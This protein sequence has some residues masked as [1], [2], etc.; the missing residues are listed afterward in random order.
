M[1]EPTSSMRSVR[2]DRPLV[3]PGL[4]AGHTPPV[5]SIR[6]LPVIPDKEPKRL[7]L[8]ALMALLDFAALASAFLLANLLYFGNA[9]ID[10][11]IA[12]AAT[13]I[14]IYFGFSFMNTSYGGRTLERVERSILLAI[15]ALLL[16]GAAVTLFVFFLKVGSEFS[17]AVFGIGLVLSMVLLGVFRFVFSIYIRRRLEGSAVT[18]VVIVDGG[19]HDPK[20]GEIVLMV[21]QLDFDPATSDPHSYNRFAKAVGHA[22]RLIVRT[23][24]SRYDPWA[25]V[26]KGI[27]TS[28]EIVSHA[29]DP[30]GIIGVDRYQGRPTMVVAAGPLHLR[31]RIFKR[32]FDLVVAVSAFA[33]LSPVLLVTAIAIRLESPG[34]VF[35]KQRRV[36]KNNKIFEIYKFRSMFDDR[37]DPD[38]A[39]LTKRDDDRITKVGKFIRRTSIDELPQLLNVFRGD[40]SI[41]GP[42]PHALSA[43]AANRL[44]WD[45]D[46]RYRHRHSVKP[47]L[48]GLAQVRGYRG[49]TDQT[50]DLTN[51]L[52]SDL[53]Y[54]QNWSLFGDVV[55]VIRT[56]WAMA[57]RNAF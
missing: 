39:T 25:Q 6:P 21:D 1:N 2:A 42:R 23:E 32:I 53:E 36:G 24:P 26:L 8:Y 56:A 19:S 13:T 12:I 33:I 29:D 7:E 27:G 44:Y 34:P 57:G 28:G 15:Q 37:S 4:A 48:T 16:A 52:R 47:G 20:P 35:F 46:P 5:R 9:F 50:E 43:K 31:D 38:A 30:F 41:V 51:R 17:R 14:P 40:M 18:T 49:P 3:A 45:V 10:H 22:D 55:L 11:G 54:V